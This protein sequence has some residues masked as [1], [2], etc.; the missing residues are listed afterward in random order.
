VE[1]TAAL[2]SLA[3]N[4]NAFEMRRIGCPGWRLQRVNADMDSPVME[5]ERLIGD[6]VVERFGWA[7]SGGEADEEVGF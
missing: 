1:S 7:R 4:A 5:T 3:E 6:A 2:P